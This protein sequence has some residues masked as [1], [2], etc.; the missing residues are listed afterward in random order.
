MAHIKSETA[1]SCPGP[2]FANELP[3]ANEL[4][5]ELACK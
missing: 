3:N 2:T 1:F 4:A 5:N